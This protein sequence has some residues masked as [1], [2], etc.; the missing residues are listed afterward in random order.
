VER[1]SFV[2]EYETANFAN[3]LL[4]NCDYDRLRVHLSTGEKGSLFELE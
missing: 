2:A 3:K 1:N 4:N